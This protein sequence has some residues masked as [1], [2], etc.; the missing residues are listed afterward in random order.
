ME[1]SILLSLISLFACISCNSDEE[2]ES[3]NSY[4][5]PAYGNSVSQAKA[6]SS[7]TFYATDWQTIVYNGEVAHQTFNN[8]KVFLNSAA[9]NNVSGIYICQV[10]KVRGTIVLNNPDDEVVRA[11]EDDR[12]GYVPGTVGTE[13]PVRGVELEENLNMPGTYTLTTNC[14]K[15]ISSLSGVAYPSNY[16]IPCSPDEAKLCYKYRSF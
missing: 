5:E 15:V 6:K 9:I 10:V 14:Y 8:Q 2:F 13:K 11:V 3:V 4:S 1:K 7:A 12:C 16:W